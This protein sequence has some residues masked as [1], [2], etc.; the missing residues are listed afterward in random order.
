M[1]KKKFHS[2][3]DPDLSLEERRDV[4]IELYEGASSHD[5]SF[6]HAL[7]WEILD[8]GIKLDTF[9]QGYFTA[10]LKHPLRSWFMN[11]RK[12]GS[13]CHDGTWD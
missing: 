7:L 12:H 9:D 11:D 8:I 6:R 4:L 5:L 10:Y 3:L 13:G 2:K 1:F